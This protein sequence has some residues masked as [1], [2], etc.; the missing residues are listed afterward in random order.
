MRLPFELLGE[1]MVRTLRRSL[2]ADTGFMSVDM[3]I[4]VSTSHPEMLVNP[5]HLAPVV[6]R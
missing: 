1:I 6:P 2:K 3:H 5:S 4:Y